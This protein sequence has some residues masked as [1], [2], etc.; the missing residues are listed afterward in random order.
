M[1]YS[2]PIAE[3][4]GVHMG[5]LNVDIMSNFQAGVSMK[6]TKRGSGCDSYLINSTSAIQMQITTKRELSAT[7]Y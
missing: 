5:N 6:P 3:K 1:S 4:L 2:L 7:T